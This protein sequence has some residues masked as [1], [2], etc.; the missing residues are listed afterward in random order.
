MQILKNNN[1]NCI[2]IDD[3]KKVNLKNEI[4]IEGQ[5][6]HKYVKDQRSMIDYF[7]NTNFKIVFQSLKQPPNL[8]CVLSL[9]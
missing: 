9:F 1:F 3:V 7:E 4:G 6:I 5:K 8:Y 2:C